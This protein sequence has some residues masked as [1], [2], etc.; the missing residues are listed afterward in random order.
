MSSG[1]P[2]PCT[3][4][5]TQQSAMGFIVIAVVMTKSSSVAMYRFAKVHVSI[6]N[7]ALLWAVSAVMEKMVDGPAMMGTLAER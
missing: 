3:P 1:F 7:R 6:L 4:Q 5:S 2:P